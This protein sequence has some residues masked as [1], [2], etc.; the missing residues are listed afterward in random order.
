M[1]DPIDRIVL[2]V[3][4]RLAKGYGKDEGL[5][6]V[7]ADCRAGIEAEFVQWS[8]AMSEIEELEIRK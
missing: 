4:L 2:L 6:Q 7:I 5:D 1:T 8:T 3:S